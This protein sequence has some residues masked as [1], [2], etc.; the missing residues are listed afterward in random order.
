MAEETRGARTS[1]P[2]GILLT[3]VISA[4][5]GFWYLLGL[6]FNLPP[7]LTST[8]SSSTASTESDDVHILS[9]TNPVI[10]IYY[11]AGSERF[12]L[13]ICCFRRS[14]AH[15]NILLLA[16][17]SLDHSGG[18][19][20]AA[21]TIIAIFFGGTSSLTVTTRIAFAMARD[22]AL[23]FSHTLRYVWPRTLSPIWTVA[24]VFGFDALLMLLPLVSSSALNAILSVSVLC[25]QVGACYTHGC[26]AEEC[27]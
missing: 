11:L 9:S 1:A 6:V 16:R 15:Y 13:E 22:G 17:T 3:C 25:Y 21:L 24:L 12:I 7:H 26:I 19:A 5:V 4:L 20:L 10:S 27:T 2:I 23:P 8:S 14:C 18:N